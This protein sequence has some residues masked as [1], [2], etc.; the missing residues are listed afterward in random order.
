[1][2]DSSYVSIFLTL[3]QKI[4]LNVLKIKREK[5]RLYCTN[6]QL[7]LCENL[8]KAIKENIRLLESNFA[9]IKKEKKREQAKE[10]ASP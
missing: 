2:L 3:E 10:I 4:I 1:M 8:N 7:H 6:K 9:A 5:E